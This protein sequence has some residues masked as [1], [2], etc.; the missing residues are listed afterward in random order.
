MHQVPWNWGRPPARVGDGHGGWSR[1]ARAW[2]EGLNAGRI[3]GMPVWARIWEVLGGKRC[4]EDHRR[5]VE[6]PW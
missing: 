4:R 6:G 2:L 1:A 3:Q 5:T